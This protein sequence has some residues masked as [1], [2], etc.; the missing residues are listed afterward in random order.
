MHTL[1]FLQVILMLT[2]SR[3]APDLWWVWKRSDTMAGQKAV[4][5][6]GAGTTPVSYDTQFYPEALC[7]P[8]QKGESARR[9]IPEHR[10]VVTLPG[11]TEPRKDY[12]RYM[13]FGQ[14]MTDG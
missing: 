6:P 1:L 12:K 7:A 14:V 4:V 3:L 9:S 8:G 11:K 2:Q 10:P 13:L 5:I